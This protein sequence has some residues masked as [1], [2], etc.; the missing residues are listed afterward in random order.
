MPRVERRGVQ[1]RPVVVTG[2]VIRESRWGEAE[3][4]KGG[5]SWLCQQL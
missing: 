3:R 2:R 1:G 4:R 5:P